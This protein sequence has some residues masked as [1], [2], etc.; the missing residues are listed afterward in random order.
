MCEPSRG[1]ALF[2]HVYGCIVPSDVTGQMRVRRG[3][4]GAFDLSPVAAADRG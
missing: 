4:D 2:P 1:G 3:A